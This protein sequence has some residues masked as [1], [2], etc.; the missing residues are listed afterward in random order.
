MLYTTYAFTKDP[1]VRTIVSQLPWKPIK[2]DSRQREFSP[3]DVY[4][5]N[6]AYKCY[7]F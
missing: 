6:K 7:G 1:T 2:E 3:G 4:N 5:V